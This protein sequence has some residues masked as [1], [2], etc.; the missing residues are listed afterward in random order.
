MFYIT[1]TLELVEAL[2]YDV[3]TNYAFYYTSFHPECS[4]LAIVVLLINNIIWSCTNLYLYVGG[5]LTVWHFKE[6]WHPICI[7]FIKRWRIVLYYVHYIMHR[8]QF[9]V[10]VQKFRQ[11]FTGQLPNGEMTNKHVFQ[12]NEKYR[13][14]IKF[15]NQKQC[16]IFFSLAR[17]YPESNCVWFMFHLFSQLS[18]LGG[19]IW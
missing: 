4:H 19:Q 10:N 14:A 12:G 11:W 17:N 15:W 9:W 6:I 7:P 5:L 2:L 16:P 18:V 1:I 8:T 3:T 13:N